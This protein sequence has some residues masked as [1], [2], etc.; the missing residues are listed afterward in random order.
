[1]AL[2][3]KVHA[4]VGT[5]GSHL[6]K[7]IN[8]TANKY[9]II[10]VN[11]GSLADDLQNAD[12]FSR[13][14][15]HT[16]YSTEQAGRGLAYYYGQIRKKEKKFYILNQDYLFGR[17][18]AEGFK[19]GMKEYYPEGQIVGEDYHKLFLTDFAP[20]LEKIKT[21]GAE[22]I[23]SSDFIPDGANL[24]KQARHMGIML[25]F[26][27][28]FMNEANMLRDLGIEGSKGLVHI[29]S[30]DMPDSFKKGPG[31]AKYYHAWINA[32]KNWKT[33]YNAIF[34]RESGTTGN[35]V[36]LSMQTYWLLNVMERAK[37]TD[38]EK[39][40]KVWEGDSYRYVNGK[41][42]MVR[43][44]DHKAIMDLGVAEYVPPEQQKISMTIP[45]YYWSKEY[46]FMGPIYRIPAAKILPWMDQNLDRCKGK[47]GW[48][49]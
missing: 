45:P 38:P 21:S 5:D 19:K 42:V 37:S 6:M 25:P 13:Y 30:F 23:F 16:Y 9:K 7:I 36:S 15:F 1:M 18:M 26:A 8:E 33:P 28:L 22:V 34:Y 14:A 20:Y 3:E 4:F 32:W 49:E 12:N 10:S 24:P 48:G 17:V 27:N 43:A 46:S 47:S 2:S 40:I 31:Y 39:I 44:C 29:D 11:I 41:V 35:G